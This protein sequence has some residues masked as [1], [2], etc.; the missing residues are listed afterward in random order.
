MA[1][2][3]AS[4]GS[5]ALGQHAHALGVRPE[6]AHDDARRSTA[7]APSKWCGSGWSRRR[8]ARLSSVDASR[9]CG[10]LEQAHD[11]RDGDGDPVG[12]VGRA[13][14]AARRPPSRAR[15]SR[16]SRSVASRGGS[17]PAA[18]HR[19][20]VAVEELGPRAL[21]DALVSGDARDRRGVGERAQHPGDVAQRR[22][23]APPLGQRRA[24][25]RPRSRS[26]ASRRSPRAPGRGGGRRGGGC[27]GRPSRRVESSRSSSRT[28]SPRP[29]IGATRLVVGQVQEDLV[30]LLVDGRG[31][32]RERLRARLL[33]ARTPGRRGRTRARVHARRSPR[34]AGAGA[35]TNASGSPR[36]LL[37]RER[38][39]VDRARRRTRCTIPSVALDQRPGVRPPAPRAAARSRSRASR[40]SAAARARGSRPPRSGG[41]PSRSAASS[42]TTDEFDCSTPSEPDVARAAPR[43]ARRVIAQNSIVPSR[44]RASRRVRSG[45]PASRANAGSPSA[46]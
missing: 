34:R 10:L 6:R 35:P 11:P 8:R 9:S 2:A 36:Q 27:A 44:P 29:A 38:P 43:A 18:L 46:S 39:A 17:R 21:L 28:A 3:R 1:A 16:S 42:S 20:E 41:R 22:A 14:S 25:A 37:E 23:L 5:L 32:E 13:R 26:R 45:R 30:D 12:P 4:T 31:Q 15:R 19:L 7:C 33:R 40:G 24:P